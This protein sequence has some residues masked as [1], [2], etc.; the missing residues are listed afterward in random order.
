MS[1]PS[2]IR[3]RTFLVPLA[4]V[5]LYYSIQL[6]ALSAVSFIFKDVNTASLLTTHYGSYMIIV[7]ALLIICL[8]L[9]LFSARKTTW[10][11]IRR[12][13]LTKGQALTSVPIAMAMLGV[14]GL[15]MVGVQALSGHVPFIKS[16]FDE[17]I[18][19]TSVPNNTKGLEAAGYY[20]G[21]GILIPIIEEVIFRGIIQGEFLATMK[22]QTAVF[23]SALIF[24]IMHMQPIQIV[25][26]FV[27][28]LI[29]GFVCLFSNSIFLSIAIHIIF[30]WI[31]GVFPVIFAEY[32]SVTG[33]L[34]FVEISFILVGVL[35]ILYLKKN[36][37]NRLLREV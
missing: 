37:R 2:P 4:G 21:V 8:F 14:V 25:Y 36:Y 11:T 32:P 1:K 29:L 12:D 15:Y 30:N 18:Q 13:L 20:I 31:G 19:N 24:G 27:C 23:L 28:G 26:A 10:M 7:S 5:A 17:Y 22:P 3:I 33:V 9:W 34:G 16:L 6:V 35:C